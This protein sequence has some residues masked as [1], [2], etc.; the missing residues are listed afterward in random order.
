M[1]EI[2]PKPRNVYGSCLSNYANSGND[3]FNT[4]NG[5]DATR[6]LRR[7]QSRAQSVEGSREKPCV[8]PAGVS[9]MVAL[10]LSAGAGTGIKAT[11]HPRFP[12]STIVQ[13]STPI[14]YR[15][16]TDM[17]IRDSI[18][19]LKEKLERR[20][21]GRRR[22]PDDT[23]SG[24]DHGERVDPA[25]GLHDGRE[26]AS[27]VGE[28]QAFLRDW[29]PRPGKLESAPADREGGEGGVGGGEVGQNHSP[30][31]PE[32]EVVVGS[33]LS[34]EG[35]GVDGG[36]VEQVCSPTIPPISHTGESDSM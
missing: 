34:R 9:G 5:I 21:T 20:S 19:R 16:N 30:L 1:D 22:K 32:T 35:D 13:P 18:S 27:N 31:C 6:T 24:T 36:A 14:Q 7:K 10:T 3:S 25:G 17:G 8:D 15:S 28:Q 33:G 4:S 29:L 23:G 26:G 12:S 2:H 11:R